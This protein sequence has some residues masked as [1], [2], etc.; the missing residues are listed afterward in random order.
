MKTIKTTNI[1]DPN[2]HFPFT[3]RSLDHIQEAIKETIANLV[4]QTVGSL[5][6]T[7]YYIVHGCIKTGA[8]SPFDITAGAIYQG[9]EIYETSAVAALAVPVG[10]TIVGTITETFRTGD[11]VTYR[12][13]QQ[14]NSH[15]IKKIVWTAGASG[16]ADVDFDDLVDAFNGGAWKELVLTSSEVTL[17]GGS[18]TSVDAGSEIRYKKVGK[19]FKFQARVNITFT[20]NPAQ[21]NVD[22]SSII[23]NINSGT[24][25]AQAAQDLN[26]A[27][28]FY[29]QIN[30]STNSLKFNIA[31]G[32][33]SSSPAALVVNGEIDLD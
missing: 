7:D 8:V 6:S 27:G 30:L 22:L 12:D 19:S 16:S 33:F 1:A 23:G 14:F 2:T 11:P 31:G 5:S 25:F 29:A 17:T 26:A 15:S 20:G 24:G 18:L 4:K 13:G 9:G 32:S 21:V 3:K 28:S 10:Q